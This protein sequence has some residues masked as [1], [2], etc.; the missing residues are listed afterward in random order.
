[1]CVTRTLTEPG[2]IWL[3]P[4]Q[5]EIDALALALL[6]HPE[7]RAARART[8]ERFEASPEF[9]VAD[10]PAWMDASVD[11]LLFSCLQFA[12]IDDPSRPKVLWT[13]RRGYTVGGREFPGSHYGADNPDR[14]YRMIG[15]SAA[16]RYRITGRRHPTH[17][18]E[19]DLGFEAI[20][21]PG[22]W[23]QPLVRLPREK[24]DI[25]ADGSFEVIA[26]GTE[27]GTRR[28]HLYLPPESK[29][30]VVRDTLLDWAAQVPNEVSVELLDGPAAPERTH[31]EIARDGVRI[32]EQCVA[33]AL[34]FMDNCLR[35]GPANQLLAF[36]RPVKWG[37]AGG[38][39]AVNRFELAE[40]EA[41][42]ITLDPLTAQY[43]AINACDPW[44]R[45]L[46]YDT[47]LASMNNVQA[48]PNTDGS[49]TFVLSPA[50]PEVHNWIDTAGLRTGSVVAR[51]ELM[52]Q[53]PPTSDTGRDDSKA[54]TLGR[55][56]VD[57]AVRESRVLPVSEVAAAVPEG[58]SRVSPEQR[59]RLVEARLADHQVRVTGIPTSSARLADTKCA[60]RRQ[61]GDQP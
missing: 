6:D 4:G 22:L 61:T 36:E 53:R 37:V 26:D 52:T 42:V 23:G 46:P 25:A 43:L 19:D 54:W 28:N 38:L 9:A 8:V 50:D 51:W 49:Y 21:P 17:P 57:A 1:M 35:A 56:V 7:V 41:L 29:V 47:G 40:D 55:T 33:F 30:V 20:P 12:A 3:S 10:A 13:L 59:A 60:T 48:Q 5:R 31:D 44:T 39:F 18:S 27:A 58:Q 24:I 2:D 34:G 11:D 14:V 15:V 32:Y 16:H 45:A